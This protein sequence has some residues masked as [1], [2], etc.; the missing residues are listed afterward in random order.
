MGCTSAKPW[1]NY[2]PA[3]QDRPSLLP[4][5]C[6]DAIRSVWHEDDH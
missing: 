3:R 4:N 1:F 2:R 6:I 5:S